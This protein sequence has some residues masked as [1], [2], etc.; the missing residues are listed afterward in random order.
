MTESTD[1]ASSMKALRSALL[2]LKDT[3]DN[4]QNTMTHLGVQREQIKSINGKLKETD[5]ELQKS[6][7]LLRKLKKWFRW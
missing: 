1:H 4:A 7:S 5:E 6:H 2:T 3:E